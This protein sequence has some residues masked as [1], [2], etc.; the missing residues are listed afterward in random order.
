MAVFRLRLNNSINCPRCLVC[1]YVIQFTRYSRSR[2]RLNSFILPQAV[3]LVKTLFVFF[4]VFRFAESL[5]AP[6]RRRLAD[7]LHMISFTASFVKH[8]LQKSGIFFGGS[9]HRQLSAFCEHAPPRFA[10]AKIVRCRKFGK[11]CKRNQAQS[12][13]ITRA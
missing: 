1:L 8:F 7:S 12:L 11:I 3:Q 2:S 13:L 10:A 4:K 6:H 9:G 5:S